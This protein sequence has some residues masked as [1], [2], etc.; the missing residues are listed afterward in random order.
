[1]RRRLLLLLLAG[2]ACCC[3]RR[4]RRLLL[5]LLLLLRRRLLLVVGRQASKAL[6]GSSGR[7][8]CARVCVHC[9]RIVCV[10]THGAGEA[11]VRAQRAL[12]LR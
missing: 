10:C 3:R 7:Q 12:W 11:R 6:V 1:V 8:L 2:A 5:L 4:R 9:V